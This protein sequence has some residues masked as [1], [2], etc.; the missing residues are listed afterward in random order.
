VS[1][2]ASRTLARAGGQVVFAGRVTPAPRTLRISAAKGVVLEWRDPVR[3]AWRPVVNARLRPDGT[4]T[5]PWTFGVAGLTIPFRAV[6][7]SEVG[8][9]LLGARSRV[10]TVRI[11]G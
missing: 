7:P 9:P 5:I 8:W 3:R 2:A 4:F 1:I 10:V 6:V 11:G